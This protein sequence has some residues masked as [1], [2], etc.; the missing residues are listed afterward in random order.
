[1][2]NPYRVVVPIDCD[3][4]SAWATVL[5]YAQEIGGK[6]TPPVSEYILLTHTKS[7]LRQTSLLNHLGEGNAK[8]LFKNEKIDSING[9][10]LRH[11]TLR[12][13]RGSL[14]GAIIIA[15]FAEDDMMET[16]DGLDGL[17]GVV[18]VPG[19]PGEVDNWIARWTP[20]VHGQQSS[21]PVK[22][23]SD[24]VIEK[25]LQSLSGR[26][27]LSNKAM[28]PRDKQ[29]ANETLR[30]LRAKGHQLDAASIKSW[31]IQ[32]SWAP[33]TAEELARL[34][35]KIQKLGSKPSIKNFFNTD[36]R[37]QR[38]NE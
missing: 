36:S 1:M 4:P 20:K 26:I 33:K 13:L 32:N 28:N 17:V 10:H 15:Y 37:Y 35:D 21:V 7:Q 12:T 24:S 9:D 30:I 34:A 23:I 14:Q 6:A 29:H 11:S 8:A 25:A 18:V 22:L 16:I 38:W 19:L 31:A 27:N 3:D 5:K 2:S